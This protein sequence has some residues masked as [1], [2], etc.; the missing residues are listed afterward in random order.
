MFA[1]GIRRFFP[2][3]HGDAVFVQRG[4]IW[5]DGICSL[6]L[7][8]CSSSLCSDLASVLTRPG[9]AAGNVSCASQ[10]REQNIL[11]SAAHMACPGYVHTRK[12][13]FLGGLIYL[14]GYSCVSAAVLSLMPAGLLGVGSGL[15]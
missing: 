3:L 13:P 11:G 2:L 9:R 8:C 1:S 14:F 4:R 7:R 10:P 12:W 15:G 6:V 5:Q